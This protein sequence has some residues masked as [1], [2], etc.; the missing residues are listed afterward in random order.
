MPSGMWVRVPPSAQESLETF[1]FVHTTTHIYMDSPHYFA[2]FDKH[3]Q[4]IDLHGI[5]SLS[6]A[7]EV[8]EHGL[9]DL[10]TT[11]RYCRVIY[12]IGTGRLA[13]AV[14][15]VLDRHPCVREYLEEESGG[16]A[17]IVF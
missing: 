6:Q 9:S 13:A 5:G 3:I 2:Q 12:G 17:I 11:E 15:D 14:K 4:V 10:M 16:S 1:F 8:L 7:L